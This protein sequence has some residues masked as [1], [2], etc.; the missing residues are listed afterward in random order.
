MGEITP[1]VVDRDIEEKYLSLAR[2]INAVN[3][4]IKGMESLDTDDAP[5]EYESKFEESL[6]L[7]EEMQEFIRNWL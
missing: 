2:T 4:I 3:D 6:E 5:A 1:I 7:H